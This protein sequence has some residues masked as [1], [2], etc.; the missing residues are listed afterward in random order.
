VEL[1]L[2][3]HGLPVRI[4]REDDEPADPPLSE[5][6]RHQAERLVRWLAP[7]PIDALYAS[8]MRRARETAEPLARARNLELRLDAGLVELDHLSSTYIPMEELKATNYEA[9]LAAVRGGLYAGIDMDAFLR[10]V[11]SALDGIASAHRGQRVAV[12]CHGGVINTWTAHVLGLA[13]TLFFDPVYTSVS[14]FLV[15]GTGERSL[16]SLNETAHLR[17][18]L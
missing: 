11:T 7:E 4:E 14:R 18:R 5:E 10:R 17:R 2:V 3:R 15:A 13:P 8:P 6:G 12:F 1:L 9:W 16:V